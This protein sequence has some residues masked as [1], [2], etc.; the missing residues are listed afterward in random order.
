VQDLQL[1]AQV[2]GGSRASRL[3]QRLYFGDKSV[4]RVSASMDASEL[5]GT[6]DITADIKDGVDPATVEKAINEELDK[7]LA[8]GPSAAELEQARTVFRAGFIRG[9]ERI[10]GFG[11]KADAL[12]ECTV[13]TG[14]PGCFRGQLQRIATR[15]PAQVKATAAKWLRSGDHTLSIVPGEVTPIVEEV[16]AKPGPSTIAAADPKFKTVASDVDRAQGV[17]VA[18]QF[19]DLSFPALQRATLSNG[20]KVIVAERHDTPV[21]QLSIEFPGGFTSDRGRK[22]G[23]ASFA[24]N[25]LDEGAG[26]Y[27]AIALGNRQEQL[28]A[29]IS[30]SAGLDSA[31]VS[32]SA[33]KENLEPS[34]AL[35]TDMIRRPRFDAAEVERVRA[36]WL[37]GIK[38]EKTQPNMMGMRVIGPVVFGAGHP[39]AIPFTGTGYEADIATLDRN[40]LLAWHQEQIRP[41][42]ATVMVVGDTTLAEIV[43]LLE[44]SFA[45]WTAP[46][47]PHPAADVSPVALPAKPRVFIVDQPGAIQSN[48]IAAQALP[49]STDK[50]TVDLEFASAVLGGDFTSRLNMNLREDK[51]W[52]YGA[53]AGAGNALGQRLWMASAPVQSD[54]TIES[55]QEMQREIADFA[56][57]KR[58]VTDEEVARLQ[59]INIR[60]LPGSYETARNVL[61][62]IGTIN[63]YGRPDDFVVWRK[64]QIEK[65]TP[66]SVQS[67]ATANFHPE[68]M[69]WV[70]VGDRA[71]IEAGIRALGIGEVTVLDADGKVVQ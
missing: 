18:T 16:A 5:G 64:G 54:K 27:D 66:A 65:M 39:Y 35:W 21:V 51:H 7:L 57:G 67:V 2:L 10:G 24:M 42:T 47:L 50:G 12:A 32:L 6:F 52:S 49:A 9:I 68:A 61:G 41:D 14:D 13:Y 15:T 25:M 30:A 22:A 56:S 40:D 31:E 34:L 36:N 48:I 17:P 43:P 26:D 20:T 38:Q 59:A 63:R 62:T 4:D 19:P 33:L 1:F 11:G 53:R 37:A 69:T 3:D 44:K 71:K 58:A 70:I 28:G 23:T 45:G 8:E 55:I 60:S 29:V 46:S